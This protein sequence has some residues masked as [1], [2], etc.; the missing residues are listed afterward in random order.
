MGKTFLTETE[1]RIFLKIGQTLIPAGEKFPPLGPEVIERIETYLADGPAALR[2]VFKVIIRAMER[3][4]YVRYLKPFSKLDE[5]RALQYLVG[6]ADAYPHKR[7]PFKVLFS[8]LK[9]GYYNNENL[10]KQLDIEYRKPEVKDEPVRWESQIMPGEEIREVL[11]LE[12]EVVVIGTGAGGAVV[13]SELAEKNNAVVMIEEGDL[14]RRSAF[15]GRPLEMQRMLYRSRGF[16]ASLG[17]VTILLPI[18]SAVGGTTLINS[19]TCFRTP[20]RELRRWRDEYGL[21]DFTPQQMEPYFKSV[22]SIYQVKTADMKH[23]GKTGEIIARGADKLGYSHGPLAR[24]APDCDGQGVCC[25]GCPTDAKRSTNVSYVPRALNN[26][27]YLLS[28]TRADKL[29]IKNGEIAGI[30]ARSVKTGQLV[31]VKAPIVVLACGTLHTP[32][33]LMKNRIGNSSGQLGRNLS[34]HPAGGACALTDELVDGHKTIPQGYMVDEFHEEGIMFEG[35]MVPMDLLASIVSHKGR[36]LQL[37][38]EQFRHLSM[39]GFMIQDTSRGRVYSLGGKRPFVRYNLNKTDLSKMIRGYAVVA[40]LFLA[41]GARQIIAPIDKW[42]PISSIDDLNS[43]LDK[44]LRALDLDISAYHPLGTCHMGDD[45]DCYVTDSYGEVYDMKN[46]FVCDGSVVPPAIGVNPQI[47]I[48]ALAA[49]T[50]EYINERLTQ[51]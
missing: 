32:L 9:A 3:G 27:A 5:N 39:F 2:K 30:E 22:E 29:I 31:R 35:A 11:E 48:S 18:G 50:A 10:F 41:G 15:T 42:K 12:A 17:N 37:F 51:M 25:Y 6:W 1:R 13:A 7:L 47:T 16:S 8:V 20:R 38:M 23:V 24:N 21:S 28:G 26:S 45:P 40:R 19:G 49:R 4:S 36:D 34:I 14:F 46:L 44:S 43:N 33:F